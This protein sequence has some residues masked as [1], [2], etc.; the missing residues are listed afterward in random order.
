MTLRR[1]I[2]VTTVCII[3]I[4]VIAGYVDYPKAPALRIGSYQKDFNV[5]LGLDLKGGSL[6]LYDADTSNVA[7][8]DRESAVEGVRDVIERRV[9]AFGVSEPVV[10][11]IRNGDSWRIQVELAGITDVQE[12]A[13][14][15]GETPSLEFKEE[16]IPVPLTDDEKKAAATEN[17]AVKKR[18]DEVLARAVRQEDFAALANE[19]SEDPGNIDPTTGEKLGGDLGFVPQGTYE[20]TFD[21]VLF[22]QM[23]DGEVF[24]QLV[25]TQYGYHIIKRIESK[26]VDQDGTQVV[27]VRASHILFRTLPTDTKPIEDPYTV[28]GL[29]GTQLKRSSVQFNQTTGEPEVLLQFNDEGTKLFSEITK[30]NIGKTVAIYLDGVPISVPQVNEEIPSGEAVISG[31][32]SLDEAKQLVER[33]NAGALPVPVTLVNQQSIDA[34]LGEQSV[35]RSLFAGIAG[36]LLIALFMIWYYRL[37]GLFSVIALILYTLIV[38]AIFKIWPVT[39][40]LAGVAGFILSIGIAVDANI[41]IFERTKEELRSGAPL[42]RAIETGFDRAWL[43]I[44]DSN[45]SSIITSFIL[46]W[47]GSSFIKGFAITLIIGIVVS[48]FSAITITRTL[49]RMTIS[50]KMQAHPWLFSISKKESLE[51]VQHNRASQS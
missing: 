36:F 5:R 38:F 2:W 43:S 27:Q 34:T 31:S 42:I 10:R 30:R 51:Y 22:T 28:T 4:S 18:A 17:E 32:F 20:Q 48:L 13:K 15:I 9:N 29:S 35:Y 7:S 23:K 45:I 50:E 41:L 19:F 12:A 14:M 39:L 40:T 44:R 37:P 25:Q 16:A 3:L 33:L 11:S 47:F 21:D 6:L 24:P 46:M 8:E 49:M 26:T 1:K